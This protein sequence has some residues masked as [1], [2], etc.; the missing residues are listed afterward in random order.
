V[1]EEFDVSGSK[2]RSSDES[3]WA[4]GGVSAGGAA[5]TEDGS[6]SKLI[7]PAKCQDKIDPSS[8]WAYPA[9]GGLIDPPLRRTDTT[10]S[11]EM[12]GFLNV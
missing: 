4:G 1:E 12:R 10:V 2:G 3:I 9:C 6:K 8:R 7:V 5:V 11:E